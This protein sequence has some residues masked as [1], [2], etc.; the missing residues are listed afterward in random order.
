[1]RKEG[2]AYICKGFEVN[3]DYSLWV[4]F[5]H[6][7]DASERSLFGVALQ[8]YRFSKSIWNVNE[9][10]KASAIS[11]LSFS[12]HDSFLLYLIYMK[13]NWKRKEGKICLKQFS[14][15]FWLPAL[16]TF[17]SHQQYKGKVIDLDNTSKI[18]PINIFGCSAKSMILVNLFEIKINK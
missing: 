18:L 16:G 9:Q 4:H 17:L 8:K 3:F 5:F 7:G 2:E 11:S 15:Q 6:I 10:N 13:R 14:G 1:M 12:L